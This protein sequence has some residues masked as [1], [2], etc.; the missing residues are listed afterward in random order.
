M[1]FGTSRGSKSKSG[2]CNAASCLPVIDSYTA[3]ICTA[4]N[5]RLACLACSS[6]RVFSAAAT[7]AVA[8]AAVLSAAALA[9]VVLARASF[10]PWRSAADWREMSSRPDI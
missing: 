9:S 7:A 2:P 8:S 5:C 10:R 3:R 4:C 6:P 1:P